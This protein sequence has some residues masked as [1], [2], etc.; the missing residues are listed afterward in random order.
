MNTHSFI[1]TTF[2]FSSAALAQSKVAPEDK[3][4]F[5]VKIQTTKIADNKES[6]QNEMMALVEKDPTLNKIYENCDK[7]YITNKS[8]AIPRCLWEEVSKNHPGIKQKVLD[9]F[10]TLQNANKPSTQ[11]KITATNAPIKVESGK[12][13]YMQKLQ[14]IITQNLDKVFST[15]V[16]IK[17]KD[18]KMVKDKGGTYLATDHAKFSELYNTH[19]TNV[20]TQSLSSY[21]SEAEEDSSGN[22]I[23]PE[24][25]RETTTGANDGRED[26][27]NKNIQKLSNASFKQLSPVECKLAQNTQVPSCVFSRCIVNIESLCL[28][29]PKLP[30]TSPS[31]NDK[32]KAYSKTRACEVVEYIKSARANI[33][34]LE[35]QKEFYEGLAKNTGPSAELKNIKQ[36]ED[37]NGVSRN[38]QDVVTLTS[39]DSEKAKEEADKAWKNL[40][41]TDQQ[42]GQIKNVEDCK[43]IILSQSDESKKA[44]TEYGMRRIA[45]AES[46]NDMSEV[47][48]KEFLKGEGDSDQDIQKM[49]ADNKGNLQDVRDLI[50]KKYRTEADEIIKSLNEKMAARDI[51]ESDFNT[52]K[53]KDGLKDIQAELQN[54]GDR[55]TKMLHFSNIV[56]AYLSIQ[57]KGGGPAKSNTNQLFREVANTSSQ[58]K[59][60]TIKIKTK[61]ESDGLRPN[62]D[63][64][65]AVEIGIDDINKQILKKNE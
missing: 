62:K 48:I 32:D 49:F 45:Q 20:V 5:D 18:G 30:Q 29:L 43:K 25:S 22:F 44:L 7:S 11:S 51:K 4:Y 23:I 40:N 35:K 27:L 47:Q 21:C 1:I 50:R 42:T 64:S 65:E 56:S 28:K 61:A 33:M 10:K 24:N 52:Q 6:T 19:L 37:E 38:S 41:C 13:P 55:Y 14:D 8:E 15:E 2:L 59:T 46:I 9:L 58:F 16:I 3:R 36:F 39:G 31:Q 54:K 17:D 12:D 53:G 60:D 57:S 63:K 26:V 34:A